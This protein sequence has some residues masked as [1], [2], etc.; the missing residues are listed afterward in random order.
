MKEIILKITP[1]V[2]SVLKQG[3]I[4]GNLYFLPSIQLDRKQYV[5]VNEVLEMLGGKWNRSKKAHVFESEE[6]AQSL[7][8]AQE[9]GEVLDQK[10]TFQ[11][12]ETPKVVA[13][14]MIELADIRYVDYEENNEDDNVHLLQD[15]IEPSAGRGAICEEIDSSRCLFRCTEL[16][17]ENCKILEDKGYPVF[18]GDFLKSMEEADRFIMNPP[19]TKGQDAEHVLHAYSLL[20]KD[21]RIVSVMSAGVKFNQQEKYKKIRELI[22]KNGEIIDLPQD[23][24][25]ESGTNVNTVLVILNK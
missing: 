23:S 20:R 24:F 18:C 9:K 12:F 19:F 21:G 14:Q 22:E 10:K 1:E 17:S 4:D 5:E 8:S 13:K 7:L 11:F 15:V 6:K 25:K 16:N 2:D 3:T